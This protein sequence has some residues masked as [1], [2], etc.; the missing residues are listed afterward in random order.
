MSHGFVI[1]S[2]SSIMDFIPFDF[3]RPKEEILP[4][5]ILNTTLQDITNSDLLS[6]PISSYDIRVDSDDSH[7][8]HIKHHQPYPLHYK[9]IHFH[10]YMICS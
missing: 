5:T 10:L 9:V 7:K 2:A 3:I 1:L 4:R 8:L 6:S